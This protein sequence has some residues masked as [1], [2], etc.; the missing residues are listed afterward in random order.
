MGTTDY[1]ND[2]ITYHICSDPNTCS[3][4]DSVLFHVY[5]GS[6]LRGLFNSYRPLKDCGPNHL[7]ARD[8]ATWYLS[9]TG[10]QIITTTIGTPVYA[11]E[12]GTILQLSFGW[13]YCGCNNPSCRDS[14]FVGIRSVPP[15]TAITQ[16]VHVSPLPGLKIGDPI[17]I[18]Q[19]I[20]T[21]DISGDSCGPHVHMARYR[22]DGK[23]TCNWHINI[24]QI[25][26]PSWWDKK[27]HPYPY[28]Y[29]P[30][31]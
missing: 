4:D 12:S 14:N 2:G 19:Q 10:Q 20:G 9:P 15:D 27:Y 25:P 18:G 29:H 30:H 5:R 7:G 22:F 26:I 31:R 21:V 6:P 23:P 3:N 28:P 13:D 24:T 11:A 1:G 17:M 16:Y 8:L